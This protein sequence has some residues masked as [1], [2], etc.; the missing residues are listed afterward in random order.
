VR[1]FLALLAV[2]AF[3]SKANA[4]LSFVQVVQAQ[5]ER[6]QD[7]LFGKAWI[8]IRGEKMRVVSGYA[9]KVLAGKRMIGPRKLMQL[10]DLGERSRTVLD[11][12][13]RTY[14]SAPLDELDYGNK[15]VGVLDKGRPIWRIV[16]TDVSVSKRKG[17]KKLLGTLC[18]HYHLHAKLTLRADD[19]RV[20]TARMDQHVWAA[21]I[22]G[23]LGKPLM[24]LIAFENAYRKA[25]GTPLSPLDYERYQVKEAAAYLRVDEGDLRRAVERIRDRYR[26]MP[27]YPVASSVSWWPSISEI[28]NLPASSAG[29]TA[30]GKVS[31]KDPAP[32]KKA[33]RP[34][35]GGGSGGGGGKGDDS[36]RLVRNEEG[37][38]LK[39][40]FVR[41][42]WRRTEKKINSMYR[43]GG[44]P[45]G[46]LR[47]RGR[48][49]RGR[50]SIAEPRISVRSA[51][52]REVYPDFEGELRAI[53]QTLLEAQDEAVR[54]AAETERERRHSAAKSP[55][56]EIY[57]E[58]HGLET[59]T[60]L[61]ASD[62]D[63]PKD[64]RGTK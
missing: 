23:K 11:P 61:P 10:V 57:T 36:T 58:L 59:E 25:S 15:L 7:G 19:G 51:R 8:E 47:S 20:E 40:R 35:R 30:L 56:Y 5:S 37:P 27:N 53:L 26:E 48:I 13:S 64:Y 44:F 45:F 62:F 54:K 16:R 41:I 49:V 1:I 42:D 29:Q 22:G 24:S 4:D 3:S 17:A 38:P 6:G 43:R 52:P 46:P 14:R 34:S 33:R 18:S 12:D 63:I 50:K 2:F 31:P 28:P 32:R 21:P 39:P 55:F 60:V 9:R